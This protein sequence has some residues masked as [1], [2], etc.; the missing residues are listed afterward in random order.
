VTAAS[1]SVPNRRYRSF[2]SGAL[3]GGIGSWML[4]T[5]QLLL[6]IEITD[7]NGFIVGLATAAQ[8]LPTFLLSA[9][10]GV[11]ADRQSRTAL[12]MAGQIV[13]VLTAAVQAGLL[14]VG[15][16]SWPAVVVLAFAFGIGAAIDGP[17]RT[18]V[19]PDLVPPV[20]VPKA[21]SFNV[22]I[23]QLGRFVGPLAA[24][25]LLVGTSYA[26]VFAVSAVAVLIFALILPRL[27]V[28]RDST[29]VV[30]TGGLREVFSYLRCN[31]RIVAVFALVGIGGLLGPN[32]TSLS[33][34]TVYREFDGS[35]TAIAAASAALAVGAIAGSIWA[36]RV[37]R[38]S[39]ASVTIVTLLVG[40]TSAVSALMPTLL[41]Y[42][43]ALALAGGVALAMVSQAT[44]LVQ[45]L[46]ADDVRGRVTGL[47]FIV[48]VGGAPIGAPVI[49][50]LGDAFGIRP[51]V[52]LAGAFVVVAAGVIG[53]F[54][55][56]GR[57]G[58]QEPV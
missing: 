52:V 27:A 10:V 47:Y 23:L 53:V 7:A 50:A 30:P 14:W 48:L 33:G 5:S 29:L 15:V 40:V 18:A 1:G 24:A 57:A 36:T 32:L 34:L 41:T 56:R 28:P 9:Y 16:G 12:L 43:F 21:V 8:Y 4:R 35:P 58:P 38:R 11:R 17:M 25:F 46:V 13:M 31:L 45:A 39:L 37:K 51:A 49:G 6:V 20:E 3:V 22:V 2:L 55:L 42:L 54:T 44:A 19:V 26:V